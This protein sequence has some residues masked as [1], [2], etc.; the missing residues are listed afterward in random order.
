MSKSLHSR[1]TLAS[2]LFD[3]PRILEELV[4]MVGT[5]TPAAAC[6]VV[7]FSRFWLARAVAAVAIATLRSR[8]IAQSKTCKR[9]VF[10][11]PPA[12]CKLNVVPLRRRTSSITYEGVVPDEVSARRK[13]LE[14]RYFF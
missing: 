8:R 5:G 1:H 3:W 14:I 12:A 11:L 7:P 13:E 9:K 4:G 6:T 2:V 10:P